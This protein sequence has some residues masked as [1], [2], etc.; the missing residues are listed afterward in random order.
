MKI[1]SISVK[2]PTW[3]LTNQVILDLIA[4]YSNGV[5]KHKLNTYQRIVEKLLKIGGSKVRYLRDKEKNEKASDFVL[6]AMKEALE[7][8]SIDKD[9]ID[10]LI[11]CGVGK[12]FLEPANAYF[13]ANAMGMECSCFDIADAC[14]SW[15]RSLEISFEFL[16]GG[17]YKNIMII[18]GEF[19]AGLAL[20]SNFVV[21]NLNQLEYT[22]PT[23]TIGEAA[24]ATI[25]SASDNEWSFHYKTRPEL[26][27]LC[28]IPLEGYEDY[29]EPSHRLGKNGINHFVAFGKDMFASTE[30]Y[31]TQLVKESIEDIDAPDIYFPHAASNMAYL[32]GAKKIAGKLEKLYTKVFPLYGN[33]VSASI[34]LGMQLAL[35]EGRLKRGDKVVFI[36]ASAGMVYGVVQFTY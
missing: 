28:N 10:L 14:M 19:N 5:S 21:R 12:G 11:Y 16:K 15:V 3:K 29:V 7:K 30:K 36:P 23:Y 1:Q 24:S 35:G 8:A 31:L 4:K 6:G 27:D 25:V 18:N 34:P 22:F 13:Y 26:C 9:D 17:R 33:V 20:P 2:I 32:A